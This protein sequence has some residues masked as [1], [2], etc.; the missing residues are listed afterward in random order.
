[1]HLPQC[2]TG[3]G[4]A[5]SWPTDPARA[6]RSRPEDRSRLW[7]AAAAHRA[8]RSCPAAA[9]APVQRGKEKKERHCFCKESKASLAPALSRGNCSR[10]HMACMC[11][12]MWACGGGA[13][14]SRRAQEMRV[15]N[16]G[17][18]HQARC[19]HPQGS[20]YILLLLLLCVCACA[21]EE[22]RQCARV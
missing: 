16:S 5:P 1:M 4:I 19:T 20:P 10:Q 12:G 21:A 9:A 8:V 2:G 22:E 13:Q 15:K 17:D 11:A 6:A 14:E 18:G 7:P 3:A